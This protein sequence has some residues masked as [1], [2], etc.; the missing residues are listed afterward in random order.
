M[1]CHGCRGDL[2]SW[3]LLKETNMPMMPPNDV[4]K[5]MHEIRQAAY[6]NRLRIRQELHQQALKAA[7]DE[8]RLKAAAVAYVQP[9]KSNA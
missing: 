6:Q 9:T 7:A 8:A 5:K 1:Q 2:H 3:K 4:I